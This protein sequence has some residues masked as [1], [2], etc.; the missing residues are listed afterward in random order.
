M[1]VPRDQENRTLETE[2]SWVLGEEKGRGE[3]IQKKKKKKENEIFKK[4]KTKCT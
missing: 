4:R 2:R 1:E 3:G